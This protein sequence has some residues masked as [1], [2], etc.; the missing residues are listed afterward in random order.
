VAVPHEESAG[1]VPQWVEG[2]SRWS[3]LSSSAIVD[4]H[5]I[6]D[7]PVMGWP[8][9]AAHRSPVQWVF[10]RT[11][12]SGLQ[13][14]GC[15]YLAVSLSAA[16]HLLGRRPEDLVQSSVAALGRLLP[17]MSGARLVD[18]AVTKERKAT[19]RA[20]P[21]SQSVR[22]CAA[23]RRAGLVLAGAWVETGWPATME[24]AV[25]SGSAAAQALVD[26]AARYDLAPVLIPQAHP[27]E[28]A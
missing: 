22:P 20:A 21:G 1:I 15:Q 16:D 3:E 26:A 2:R 11:A 7:R 10:D 25:R 12:S 24:G 14:S 4:V 28:V 8:V 6:L 23:T 27:K 18:S 19:F 17:S 9:M 5:L 13:D